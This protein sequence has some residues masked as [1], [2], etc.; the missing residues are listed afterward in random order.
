MA[1]NAIILLQRSFIRKPVMK[2]LLVVLIAYFCLTQTC[3]A[4]DV[5]QK[6]NI[7][8]AIDIAVENNIDYKAAKIDVDI[9]K[10]KIKEA[11][12]LQ[13]PDINIFYNLGKSGRGNPQQI[14]MS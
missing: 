4:I 1:F 8:E 3:F 13:N 5:P 6:I 11:N 7:K 12:R 14:G 2:K 10:N 9:A